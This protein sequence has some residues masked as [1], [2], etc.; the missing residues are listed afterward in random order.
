MTASEIED[1]I[2]EI[3]GKSGGA[4]SGYDLHLAL[5]VRGIRVDSE[6]ALNPVIWDLVDRGEVRFNSTWELERVVE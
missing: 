6:L 1:A 3:L 5:S 4:V 2:L